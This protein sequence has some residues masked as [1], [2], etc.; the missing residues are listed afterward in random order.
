MRYII[1]STTK[2][3]FRKEKNEI[4]GEPKEPFNRRYL[5]TSY[6]GLQLVRGAP[7]IIIRTWEWERGLP[8]QRALRK[9]TKIFW[10]VKGYSPPTVPDGIVQLISSDQCSSFQCRLG[11]ISKLHQVVDL[12]VADDIPSLSPSSPVKLKPGEPRAVV[13]KDHKDVNKIRFHG[14][15]TIRGRSSWRK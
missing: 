9:K 5:A 6:M 4:A 15:I 11:K 10:T 2:N 3:T 13:E 14:C 8:M 12:I 1:L 7:S